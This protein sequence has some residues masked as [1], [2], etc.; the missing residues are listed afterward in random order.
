MI[1]QH[2]R[3]RRELFPDQTPTRGELPADLQAFE[4]EILDE[5]VEIEHQLRGTGNWLRW[6]SEVRGV[7]STV[8]LLIP[9]IPQVAD[10]AARE[11]PSKGLAR[12]LKCGPGLTHV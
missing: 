11:T 3:L 4:V 7:L 9:F 6:L 1:D 5:Y 10:L 8:Q 2:Y 12:T